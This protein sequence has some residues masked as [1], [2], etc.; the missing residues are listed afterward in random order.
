MSSAYD[1]RKGA[2]GASRP[3]DELDEIPLPEAPPDDDEP[4]AAVVDI[5]TRA[6]RSPEEVLAEREAFARRFGVDFFLELQNPETGRSRRVFLPETLADSVLELGPLAI[7]LDTYPWSFDGGVWTQAKD[8]IRDRATVLLGEEYK[9]DR[10]TQAEHHIYRKLREAGRLISADPISHLINFRNGLLDWRTGEL[11]EHS[12]DV[13]STIQLDTE[14]DETAACPEFERFLAEVLPADAIETMWEV[15]GYTMFSGN[16]LH[17]AVML[18]GRGRNGKGT[19]LRV[20][21]KLLGERNI[22]AVTLQGLSMERGFNRVRLYNK[23]ANIAGDLDP[24]YLAETGMFKSITGQDPIDAEY[25]GRDGFQFTAHAVPLFSANEIPAAADATP[26]YFSRW[27]VIPFPNDFRGRED[28]DLDARL[29]TPEELRGIAYTAVM[30]LRNLMERRRFLE[31]E[32]TDAA[33]KEFRRASDHVT[34]W[35]EERC[36]VNA[37][38]GP[39]HQT[40]LYRDYK[41]WAMDNGHSALSARKFYGRL[42]GHGLTWRKTNGLESFLGVKLIPRDG[43]DPFDRWQTGRPGV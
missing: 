1:E 37:D 35:L 13:L 6:V 9:T 7:G 43:E 32:S 31:C 25:K 21:A 40:K 4:N 2:P 12:P 30:A 41:E 10:A 3:V 34:G 36:D 22:S 17:K 42:K 19:V 28:P 27:L 29:T 38:W 33:M 16:P 20:I 15:I 14:W 8:V 24:T 5:G 18:T 39:V 26:G 23:L 11:R